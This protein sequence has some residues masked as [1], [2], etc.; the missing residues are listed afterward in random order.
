MKASRISAESQASVQS[1]TSLQNN[2]GF[3]KTATIIQSPGSAG[4]I[5]QI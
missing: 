4:S 1:A 2:I 5:K 3:R